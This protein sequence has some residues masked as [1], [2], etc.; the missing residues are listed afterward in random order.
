[1]HVP[2]L[3]RNISDDNRNTNTL[4]SVLK[5]GSEVAAHYGSDRCRSDANLYILTVHFSYELIAP[6]LSV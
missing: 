6:S 4:S 2:F 1:M 5:S 3:S